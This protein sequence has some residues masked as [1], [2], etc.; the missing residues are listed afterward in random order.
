MYVGLMF[1]QC[2]SGP[3]NSHIVSHYQEMVPLLMQN[4]STKIETVNII[5]SLHALYIL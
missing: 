5:I 2:F 1:Y 4:G 3:I